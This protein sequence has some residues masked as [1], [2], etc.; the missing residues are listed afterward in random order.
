MALAWALAG[1]GGGAG[2]GKPSAAPV[3]ASAPGSAGASAKAS[4]DPQ[5]AEKAAVLAAYASMSAEQLRAYRAAD[6]KGTDLEKYATAEALGQIRNDLARMQEAGT[7]V[8]GDIGHRAEVTALDLDAKTPKATLSDCVDLSKYETFD[9]SAQKVI[10]LPT[11]QPL[12]Y[13]MTA[14]AERWEGRWMVT[15]INPLG[16]PTC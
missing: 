1:C 7:V 10:P 12:R 8:R 15:A 5:A 9:N 13:V 3:A 4:A 6:A 2:D 11:E 14:T 16:G